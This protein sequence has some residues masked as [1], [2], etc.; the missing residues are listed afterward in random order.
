MPSRA[1]CRAAPG[2]VRASCAARP[3][4]RRPHPQREQRRPY[5]RVQLPP[6]WRRR[7]AA[8]LRPSV[9]LRLSAPRPSERP[10]RPSRACPLRS[11]YG[12]S[13]LGL[14]HRLLLPRDRLARTL[15]RA[16]VR[17]RALATDGQTSA[18]TEAAVAADLLETL[19]VQRGFAAEVTFDGE[20]A[21]DDL[22]D[23]RDLWLGEVA[24]ADAAVDARLLEDVARAR[25]ADAEDVPQRHVD[26]LLARDV[27]TG[28]T[29]HT[30]PTPA[31]ACASAR[32]RSR[33]SCPPAG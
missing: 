11:R 19:D 31:A 2:D 6:S 16:R 22:A 14:R 21:V 29:C 7:H 23:L 15:P 12:L 13:P 20:A 26:A 5:R 27:D 8:R 28:D 3:S 17:A 9:R 18:V 33:G 10:C 24:H 32:S 4:P 1:R 25:R 30:S